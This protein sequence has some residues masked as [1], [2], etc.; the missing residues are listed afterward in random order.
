MN[1]IETKINE[2]LSRRGY[3]LKYKE[4][5]PSSLD[6]IYEMEIWF[7]DNKCTKYPFHTFFIRNIDKNSNFNYKEKA[8]NV[9][10]NMIIEE[11]FNDILT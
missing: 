11:Y 6:D 1:D 9:F 4:T 10:L 7:E 5:Y 8:L 3:V 2:I